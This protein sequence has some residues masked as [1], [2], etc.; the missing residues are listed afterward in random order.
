MLQVPK[1]WAFCESMQRVSARSTQQHVCL[2]YPCLVCNTA[3][4]VMFVFCCYGRLRA[5]KIIICVS[6][7]GK[8]LELCEQKNCRS[9]A[10]LHPTLG[11]ERLDGRG[12]TERVGPWPLCHRINV[13]RCAVKERSPGCNEKLVQRRFTRPG[14]STTASTCCVYVRRYQTRACVIVDARRHLRCSSCNGG[15]P[16]AFQ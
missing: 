8:F 11:S 6:Q 3:S 10:A 13:K 7:S 14:F 5:R 9:V 12:F 15:M 4:S 2:H 1:S 16:F